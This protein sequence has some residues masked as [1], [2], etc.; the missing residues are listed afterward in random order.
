MCST[1]ITKAYLPEYSGDEGLHIRLVRV[2]T[3][4]I[5]YPPNDLV[6]KY[7]DECENPSNQLESVMFIDS[8]KQNQSFIA[9]E[10]NLRK[11]WK[12]SRLS[13]FLD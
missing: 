12:R 9:S 8:S 5:T 4:G 7:D 13:F 3:G 6:E 2:G 10:Y 11:S 1:L